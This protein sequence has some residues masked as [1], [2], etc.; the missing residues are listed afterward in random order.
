MSNSKFR[1]AHCS[2][3]F[4]ISATTSSLGETVK[5]PRRQAHPEVHAEGPYQQK[6]MKKWS[7]RVGRR[8][9]LQGGPL[10]SPLKLKPV[11]WKEPSTFSATYVQIPPSSEYSAAESTTDIH[12]WAAFAESVVTPAVQVMAFGNW[13]GACSRFWIW[14]SSKRCNRVVCMSFSRRGV[15]WIENLFHPIIATGSAPGFPSTAS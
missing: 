8:L 10:D 3:Y 2:Q 4:F 7:S 13:L 14:S 15:G 1:V 11:T 9:L 12:L 6:M 5:Y